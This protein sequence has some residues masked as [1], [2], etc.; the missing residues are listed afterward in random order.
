MSLDVPYLNT[1]LNHTPIFELYVVR[2][3]SKNGYIKRHVFEKRLDD[4]LNIL[5]HSRFYYQ[6]DWGTYITI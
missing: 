2:C 6:H 1:C 4:K 3:G 5:Y